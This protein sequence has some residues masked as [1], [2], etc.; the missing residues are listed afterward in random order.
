MKSY[1]V[2]LLALI[3]LIGG[4]KKL[5]TAFDVHVTKPTVEAY[6]YADVVATTEN[7]AQTYSVD[8]G[9]SA[10]ESYTSLPGQFTHYYG[11]PGNYNVKITAICTDEGFKKCRFQTYSRTVAIEVIPRAKKYA[12]N[13]TCVTNLDFTNCPQSDT[14][15][16]STAALSYTTQ[17]KLQLTNLFGVSDAHI[18]S[19]VY[20]PYVNPTETPGVDLSPVTVNGAAFTSSSSAVTPIPPFTYSIN[21][22]QISGQYMD[23][24]T[25]GCFV[26]F[27]SD[28]QRQ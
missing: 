8:W 1:R 28:L 20:P 24:G 12:G 3:L 19:V 9:N 21:H 16:N 23:H 13:Y 6:E 10:V 7:V 27:T 15:I 5:E 22:I 2:S 25:G 17:E 18:F 4:C 11:L 14:T 26:T